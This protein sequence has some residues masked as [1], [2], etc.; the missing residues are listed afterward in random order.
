[1]LVITRSD[2][3]RGSIFPGYVPQ[4]SRLPSVPVFPRSSEYQP[5]GPRR[6]GTRF[7]GFLA[8]PPSCHLIF[9]LHFACRFTG[10]SLSRLSLVGILTHCTHFVS[11]MSANRLAQ[12]IIFLNPSSY[13][14]FR[15]G[16]CPRTF[17]RVRL[18]RSQRV[19]TI[20]F[21]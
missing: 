11:P 20:L 15:S 7:P 19:C 3:K 12:Q 2:S 9:L 21:V 4:P 6:L 16:L 1:M 17:L 8:T 14:R 18:S 5:S 13:F 10:I